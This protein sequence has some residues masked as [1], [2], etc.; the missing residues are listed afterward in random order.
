MPLLI[1]EEHFAQAG[2]SVSGSAQKRSFSRIV[3]GMK[4]STSESDSAGLNRFTQDISALF[5]KD[6]VK[7]CGVGHPALYKIS[8]QPQHVW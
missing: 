5:G 7:S 2:H 8:P 6:Q 1:D 3:S 4:V